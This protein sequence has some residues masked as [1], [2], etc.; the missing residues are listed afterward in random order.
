LVLGIGLGALAAL[1]G[2]RLAVSL[3]H[4]VTPTD[5]VTYLSVGLLLLSIGVIACWLPARR[6]TRLAPTRMMQEV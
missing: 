3:V 5:P 4:G 2:A 6:A 1:A